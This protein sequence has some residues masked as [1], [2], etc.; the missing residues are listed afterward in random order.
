[1]R[2]LVVGSANADLVTRVERCPLPGETLLGSAFFTG[3]GG[4]G[5]NQAVAAA[6]LG[7][8]TAFLGCVGDDA[9]GTMLETALREA[10][11]DVANMQR[12]ASNASGTAVI[13]VAEDGENAIVVT[14][15]ANA[16]VTP[17]LIEA[18][19]PLFAQADAMIT[20]F[21]IPLDSVAAALRMAQKHECIVVLD[22]GAAKAAVPE[23]LAGATIVSPNETETACLTGLNVS[24]LE[25]AQTAATVLRDMGAREVVLKLGALGAHYRGPE[26]SHYMPA[27]Q[28]GVVDTT[29]AGDAFTAALAVRWPK[30]NVEDALRW[31]NAAG[32]LACSREGAQPSMP[33]APEVMKLIKNGVLREPV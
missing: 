14:P 23:V 7:A 26:N 11:V 22:C 29:A 2:V 18:Q 8:D 24:N 19:E 25:E 12:S 20:Q 27:F 28:V 1:M 5:A 16:E 17:A 9:L 13:V 30:G 6:R 10:G 33:S 32:A 4:K 3:P 15:G 31:A 21:E